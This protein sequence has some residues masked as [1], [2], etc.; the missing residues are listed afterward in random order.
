MAENYLTYKLADTVRRTA[1]VPDDLF[2]KYGVKRGLRNEDGSGVLVGLTKVGDVI[3]YEADKEGVKQPIPGKLL[4]RGYDIEDLVNAT[5]K[6][7]R[8]GY[9][10]VAYLLLSGQLPDAVELQQ[11]HELIIQN[12]PLPHD[13][14]MSIMSLRGHDIMNVLARSVLE[15]YTYD[16]APDDLSQENAMAQS[17]ALVAQFPTIIAYAFNSLRNAKHGLPMHVRL[18]VPELSIAENFLYMTRKDFSALDAK[19]LDLLLVL[20]AEHGGGN[21]STFSVRVTSS[22]RT[23]IYSA[24]AAGIGSLR[25]P[26]H[27]G[28]NLKVSGMHRYLREEVSNWKDPD[29]VDFHLERILA[30]QGFDKSG[31][32]YGIGHAV[33][34]IS[35][36]RTGLLRGLARQLAAE[37]GRED[38]FDFMELVEQRAG[39][40]FGRVKKT[41]APMPANVDFYS[42]LVYDLVGLPEEI[43]TPLFAMAR[44]AGWVAHRNEELNFSGQ[45]IIR[46]A[47]RSVVG[48]TK[49]YIPLNKRV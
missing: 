46:P 33:Y 22:T 3:G 24:I 11:F 27:G 44:I 39:I 1:T 41:D 40:A 21:N 9:E 28:A 45:R 7:G 20:M 34:T 38:E 26:L 14:I 5:M 4:Y 36:P 6:E 13:A 15:L 37:K 48:E 17:V 18:P 35:D 32:I 25:G 2:G 31:L 49:K 47:F 16:P 8:M 43:F 29:E 19:T 42:G 30:R 12:M 23:D 10:E